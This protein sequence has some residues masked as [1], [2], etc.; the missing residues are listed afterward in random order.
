MKNNFLD[1]L[2]SITAFNQ[3][4]ASKIFSR[5]KKD[6]Q[7]IVLKNNIPSAVLLSPEEYNR[8][9]EEAGERRTEND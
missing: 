7:I 2:V 3:G 8:L 5:L 9:L 4:Q 1:N 6:K